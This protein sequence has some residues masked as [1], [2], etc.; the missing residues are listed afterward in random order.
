MSTATTGPSYV[1]TPLTKE[2]ADASLQSTFDKLTHVFGHIPSFFG[3]MARVPEALKHFLP[4]YAAVIDKG[5]VEAK[6]KELAY[7]KTAQINGCEY[8]FRAHTASGKKNGVTDEQIKTL[9]FFR[10]SNAFDE[11]EKAVLLY[12]ERVTRGA[13]AMRPAALQELKHHF[14][15]DQIVELTLTISIANFTN[16]FNDAMLTTPDIGDVR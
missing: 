4:L 16:R 8:C 2:Q 13:S 6:Y 14:T 10:R 12:A 15:D 5:S 1:I 11:K 9:A 3:V 7:L